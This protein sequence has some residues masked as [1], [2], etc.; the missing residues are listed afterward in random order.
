MNIIIIIFVVQTDGFGVVDP[1]KA[2]HQEWLNES[3]RPG[4]S[5]IINNNNNG[6]YGM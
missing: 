5:L 3:M 2:L 6:R 1:V 4:C